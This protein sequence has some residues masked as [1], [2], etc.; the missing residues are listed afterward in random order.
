[1]RSFRLADGVTEPGLE[2]ITRLAAFSLGMSLAWVSLIDDAWLLPHAC[3]GAQIARVPRH[4]T[5]CEAAMNADEVFVVDLHR[6]AR[7][8]AGTFPE[9][10]Q[11]MQVY[12]GA[13]LVTTEGDRIGTLCVMDP[14]PE[15]ILSPAEKASLA[16]FAGLVIDWLE[17][18]R[19]AF[20]RAAIAGFA[21]AS[22]YAFVSIDGDGTI[23]FANR[24]CEA[25]FGYEP[26]AML[27]QDIDIIIPESFR[28][29]HKA[30]VARIA[31]GKASKLAGQTIELNAQR[32]DGTI[33]PIEFSLSL[34]PTQT[35]TGTGI[36]AIIRDISEWRA[37]DATLIQMAHHDKLTGLTNRA[38]FDE[39]LRAVLDAG[40]PA[41]VL[42]LDLDGFKEVNDSLGHATGDAL[43]Q[44][45]AV[46]LPICIEEGTIIARFGGDEFALLLPRGGGVQSANACAA[47]ILTGFQAPFQICGHTFHVGLSIGA[48]IGNAHATTPDDLIADAD[49]ALYQAKRDG[50]R[51][52][53]LFAPAMRK[54]VL[55]RRA[56]HDELTRAVEGAQLV[57]HYQ[58]QVNLRTG[59]V[60]GVE[61]LLRWQHP[62][63]GLLLPGAFLS[64]LEA[65]PL[66]DPVGRWIIDEACRQAAAWRAARLP[67]VRVAVNLFDAQ[68]K[69]GTLTKDV[70]GSLARYTLPP[71]TLEIEVTE[72]IALRADDA[73]LEPI[74]ELH[75]HGVAI[76]FDDFGTGYASLSSLKR[77]P[78]TRLKIDRSFVR[79][80]LTDRHDAEII[81]AVLAM[82]DS[83][84]LD[85][86]AEGIEQPEQEAILLAMG[87]REGQGYLYGRATTAQGVSKLLKDGSMRRVSAA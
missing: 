58:P 72:R 30:G 27:G 28:E 64:A 68:L 31:T 37:R 35:G 47:A 22:E 15:R 49:L 85:V 46:R 55:A 48:A 1:M 73:I 7:F 4:G 80:V 63:R 25:I 6:D 43:L 17:A 36:G 82:A 59:R 74:R 62:E 38:C 54:A 26:G 65:H 51:C 56:L 24:A 76:A 57:L 42:L 14:N 66:A 45:V 53:R 83:F 29:A 16:S 18:R 86:I 5:P 71:Q 40:G 34:W 50:R 70:I 79:D 41:T 2:R 20:E 8:A 33:F 52:M 61:A 81:R 13:A 11:A 19:C 3:F 23:T 10:M 39:H 75:A 9:P 60:V 77:F 67:P 44:A 78:L 12:A 69:G 21:E 84:G 32:R 87:C